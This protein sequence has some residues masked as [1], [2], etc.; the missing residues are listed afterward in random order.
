MAEWQRG[1]DTEIFKWLPELGL[2]QVEARSLGP[3]H[4]SLMLRGPRCL[5][6]PLL[7]SL[8]LASSWTGTGAAGTLHLGSSM[9][10]LL[11]VMTAEELDTL[12][13]RA[14]MG[15]GTK[16][17]GPAPQNPHVSRACGAGH[18]FLGPPESQGTF[19]WLQSLAP[20][21]QSLGSW[22]RPRGCE[23]AWGGPSADSPS[24]CLWGCLF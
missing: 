8:V 12:G 15:E 5:G 3:Y 10:F 9:T 23:R 4:A 20:E 22:A 18:F 1:R 16:L 2:D 19:V 24:C 17:E 6:R 13:S 14:G 21:S 11:P 7:P